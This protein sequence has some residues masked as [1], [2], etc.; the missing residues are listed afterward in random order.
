MF[1]LVFIVIFMLR[2]DARLACVV[3]AGLPFAVGFILFI[4]PMQREGGR[5]TPTKA[6]I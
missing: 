1:N 2:M 3:L 6:A 5:R 4:K